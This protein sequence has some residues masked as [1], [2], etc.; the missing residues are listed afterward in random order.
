MQ[1]ARARCSSARRLQTAVDAVVPVPY[2][3][4]TAICAG[5]DTARTE[6]LANPAGTRGILLLTDGENNRPLGVCSAAPTAPEPWQTGADAMDCFNDN[7]CD[8]TTGSC[9]LPCDPPAI[10][11]QLKTNDDIRVVLVP[12]GG[13]AAANQ[14]V[15]MARCRT[16]LVIEAPTRTAAFGVLRGEAHYG[17]SPSLTRVHRS[18]SISSCRTRTRCTWSRAP[19]A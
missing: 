2:G 5:L 18:R 12:T 4:G 7:N 15:Q 9:V 3:E 1:G 16:G 17:E 6:L 11:A 14:A 8:G 13:Q 19:S 10:A